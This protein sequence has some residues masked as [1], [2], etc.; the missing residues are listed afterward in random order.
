[1]YRVNVSIQEES[2]VKEQS[3]VIKS[4]ENVDP[5]FLTFGVYTTEKDMYVNILP[6]LKEIWNGTGQ[7]IAFAPGYELF[8]LLE[9]LHSILSKR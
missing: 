7:S 4:L 9:F 5:L 8:T 3:L 2:T 6:A 1:M